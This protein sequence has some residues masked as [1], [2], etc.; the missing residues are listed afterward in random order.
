MV[1]I[2][3]LGAGI[4]GLWQAFELRRRGHDVTLWD[5]A[6][7]PGGVRASQLAGAM[8]A[9]YC[10]GEPGHELA[11][12]LGLDSLPLW[13][14]HY[15]EMAAMGT[16]VVAAARD[17]ADYERFASQTQGHRR[18]ARAELRELEP[19]LGGRFHE[20]LYFPDE[21]HVEP[22][23]AMAY[24]A[25]ELR[26]MGVVCQARAYPDEGGSGLVIDCRGLAARDD[27]KT[28][29]GVRGERILIEAKDVRLTRPIRLLHPRVPFYIVPWSSG[30]FMIG[31][32]LIESADGGPATL[33]SAME[34]LSCAYALLPELGEAR[35]VEI[36]AGVR[37]SFPDNAPKIVVRGKRIFVNGL[38][39]HG[40]LVS[41]ILAQIAADY[42]ETGAKAE[43]VVFEDH[44]E[45]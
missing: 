16:L 26:R 1:K 43:G 29:R 39:R 32:T 22:G 6:G 44:G 33:R 36:A 18:M 31:A 38:Y 5:R 30:H 14:E 9:P 11:C 24:F 35:I 19:A 15:P 37:P 23:A 25:R 13:R 21:A 10:E 20:G 28:L 8:L 41:P 17:R 4:V 27:L 42:I 3:V 2:D 40:F 7:I 45:W 34:L 12:K